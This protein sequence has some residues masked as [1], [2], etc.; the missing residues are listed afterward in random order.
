MNIRNAFHGMTSSQI[1]DEIQRVCVNNN[2]TKTPKSDGDQRDAK[3]RKRSTRI[4]FNESVLVHTPKVAPISKD[5]KEKAFYNSKDFARFVKND[6]ALIKYVRSV[7]TRRNLNDCTISDLNDLFEIPGNCDNND[8]GIICLRGLECIISSSAKTMSRRRRDNL[9]R[10]VLQEQIKQKSSKG[11]YNSI[12]IRKVSV[13]NSKT[14]KYTALRRA[15]DDATY[16]TMEIYNKL[17]IELCFQWANHKIDYVN[18]K[19]LGSILV[20]SRDIE[21]N[22]SKH[23]NLVNKCRIAESSKK[24]TKSGYPLVELRMDREDIVTANFTSLLTTKHT[25]I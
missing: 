4:V 25:I 6:R 14:C 22:L 5:E 12:M 2:I 3:S 11:V 21:V 7:S 17:P 18:K 23:P 16:A 10:A 9:V 20:R 13:M 8:D 1:I 24:C 15:K 19:Q